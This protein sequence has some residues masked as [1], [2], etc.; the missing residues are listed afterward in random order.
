MHF[1]IF[2]CTALTICIFNQA[3]V[4]N[5]IKLAPESVNIGSAS[6]A[7]FFSRVYASIRI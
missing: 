5:R 1:L 7:S 3:F 2:I 4:R 6:A